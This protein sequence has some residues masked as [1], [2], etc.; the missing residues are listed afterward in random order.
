MVSRTAATDSA[1]EAEKKRLD[2]LKAELAA[3]EA[4]TAERE[5][6]ISVKLS[7]LTAAERKHIEA[8][9][10]LAK[11]EA[12]L[13]QRECILEGS[14]ADAERSAAEATARIEAREAALATQ[15]AG[16]QQQESELA[17]RHRSAAKRDLTRTREV[18]SA[19][20]EGLD[21]AESDWWGKQLG[22]P[23]SAKK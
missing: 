1:F 16:L 10:E 13:A 5:R 12:V 17:D 23:L 15:E 18:L 8:V 9:G 6:Q 22:P 7:K 3:A 21:A 19:R 20:E 11:Q 2:D 4:R 14:L